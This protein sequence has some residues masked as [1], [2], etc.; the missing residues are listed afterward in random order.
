[1]ASSSRSGVTSV[2]GSHAGHAWS[3]RGSCTERPSGGYEA[4]SKPSP[5]E[6]RN[7]APNELHEAARG[8]LVQW[9]FASCIGTP[10]P[11]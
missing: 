7:Y 10:K 9:G 8:M 5:I 3:S 1:M 11:R 6:C 4:V 2:R